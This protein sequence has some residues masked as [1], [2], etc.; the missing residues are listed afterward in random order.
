MEPLLIIIQKAAADKTPIIIWLKGGEKIFGRILAH[1]H[2]SLTMEI[3]GSMSEFQTYNAVVLIEQ[4]SAMAW[5]VP[6]E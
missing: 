4:I 6:K 1:G 3:T 2:D 5:V